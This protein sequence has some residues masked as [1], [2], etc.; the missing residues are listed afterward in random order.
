MPV[1]LLNT[2]ENSA[3]Q[4]ARAAPARPDPPPGVVEAER[5]LAR[6][7]WAR[8][9]AR[10]AAASPGAGTFHPRANSAHPLTQTQGGAAWQPLGPAAVQSQNYGLVTGRISALALDPSDS[11]GNR[12]FVGTTGGG[13]WRSGN[14]GT[15]SPASIVFTP[16]TD[17]LGAMSGA[18]ETSISIGALTVQPGGTGVILA[19]TGDPNDA[20]DSY[21]GAGILRS[22]DGGNTWDLIQSTA[23]QVYSFT[24]EGFAGFAWS[25]SNPQ[26]VVA[27]VS[28]AYEGLVVSADWANSSYEGL[29]YSSDGGVTWSLATIKDAAGVVQGPGDPFAYPDGNAATSVVWNPVRGLFVAAIRYHGYYQS[30]D[31]ITWT[32]MAAQPG[33]NLTTAFC[34]A[35]SGSTGSPACPI[36]RGTLAVNPLTGDTFAWTV[37]AFNQDQGLWQDQCAVSAG[38]CTSQAITFARQWSTKALE[39]N[40]LLGPATIQNGDY[41]LAL[42]A[43]P[44][45]QDTL[46]LAGANDLWKCSL[47]M[48]CAWRNTTNSTAGFCSGV[49]E[50]QHAVAWNAANPLEIFVGNDSGLW[51]STD[52]IGETGPVC[53]SNDSAH[54]QNLNGSLGSLAEVESLSQV[55]MTPYTLLAG[56]GANGT[57]GV[58]SVTGPTTDW[59]EILGGEGGPVA[60]DAKN[61]V[62]WYVNNQAGVSIYLCSQQAPCTP[63]AFGS[64]PVVNDADVGGDGLVMTAPAPFL[65]D[66]VDSTQLLIGTCRVWRGPADGVGWTGADAISPIGIVES[67]SPDTSCSGEGLIRSLAA[68]ALPGGNEIVYVGMY[69]SANGGA[70]LP[71]HVLSAVINPSSSGSPVWQDLTGNPVVNDTRGLNAFELDISSILIDSNDPTGNTVYVTVAGIQSPAYEVQLVYRSI[72]GGGHW[73]AMTAN[74]PVAPVN[75][76]AVDP[77]DANTVYVATDAGVYSTRQITSCTNLASGCWSAFG[78]G[79]PQAP[80]V[81]VS[82]SPA[83]ATV[84][85]LV[86]ATYGRG[87][88]MTPLWTAGENPTAATATPAALT[89]PSQGFGTV[90]KA[91]TVTVANAGP[92]ALMPAS[93]VTSGDFTESD[94]CQNAILLPGA[95]CAIQI[96]FVPSQTGSRAGFLTVGG[97][98]SGGNLTVALNG[99][100]APSSVFTMSPATLSFGPV[101][102]GLTS[103]LLQVTATNSGAAAAPISS[104][105]ATAPFAVVTNGCGT[106][107]AAGHAC[108]LTVDFAPTQLGAATGTLTFADAAGT[109]TVAL[110]GSGASAPTDNLSPAAL[111]FPAT[112]A[113]QAS[114]P[115]IVTLTNSGGVNLTLISVSVSGA[116]TSSNN[117]TATLAANSTCTISVVFSPTQTGSQTGTLTVADA[118]RTQTVSLTGSGVQPPALAV[119]PASLTFTGQQVGVPSSPQTLTVSNTGGTSLANVGFQIT[120]LSAISFSTGATTCGATLAAN[121]NCTVQIVF[122][123]ATAGGSTAALVVSSSTAGVATVTVSLSGTGLAP[124]GLSVNPSQLVFP[125]VAP[126]QSSAPQMVNLTNTGAG[127]ANSL[128]LS[129]PSPFSLVENTCGATLAA[130][131]SCSTG[132]VFSPALNGTFTGALT[133]GSPSLA[134]PAS[135]PLSGT[136]GIPGSVQV[137]PSL[138]DFPQTGVGLVSSPVTVTLTNPSGTTSLTSFALAVTAGFRLVNNTCPTTLTAQAS[139]TVGVEFAP[140]SAGT[141]SGSLTASSSAL[142]AGAFV[143][144]QGMG[145]DFALAPSGM[146]AQSVASGQAANFRL[147]LT[148]LLGSQGVFTFKCASLPPYSACVF[149]PT[150]EGV[151]ANSSGY[152]GVQIETGLAQTSASSSAK[153]AWRVLP[154]ACGLLLIPLALSPRR[155]ALLLVVA[156]AILAGGVTSCTSASLISGGGTNRT[157]PGITPAGTYSITVTATSNGIAHP[158]T[159]TLTVD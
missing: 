108:G 157:G 127:A 64:S 134:A 146:S 156:L 20:L 18:A 81:N 43:V 24:G 83:T 27:A 30:P 95:S 132:V 103:G 128:T 46:L 133:I 36:F 40:S 109:Q 107:L 65:V 44:S 141:G 69:G 122:T 123:P 28:Q 1:P 45:Q 130:G 148:P 60:I 55:G 78:S 5:F 142:A 21:Y 62:N 99:T 75:S 32:R 33:S 97:N 90:S 74:L 22:A 104:V 4:G 124:A 80:A 116:F 9:G 79:L 119:T 48:G 82:A 85:V 71:G 154:L 63:A 140:A 153:G 98:L 143:P 7:G 23:D 125:I 135:V 54:F 39:T 137:A 13:V 8:S 91:Q 96:A 70:A 121:S 88:W 155:R 115:E 19:G 100:G 26:R 149:S 158:I 136:G 34:P 41:N 114:A 118:V 151:T 66:P 120:G 35:N 38:A 67:A 31:G 16:L 53:S 17:D 138:I 111:T 139:C 29:Y 61:S 14:A 77:Q 57:A 52:A 105:G 144:L 110:T 72:D 11:T 50:Y 10:G 6:R 131:A 94:N 59:P 25:T 84:H 68:M 102:V 12:L 106:S 73:S 152:E 42:A 76:L 58:K 113:G 49:G 89:F 86:A 159:L 117:C 126:G 93:I 47:A 3:V 2:Q 51:R 87:I 147:V 145:F 129:A 112:A 150:S 92:S 101:Q 15:S 56:L 37:D